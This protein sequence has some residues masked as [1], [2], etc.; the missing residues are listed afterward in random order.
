MFQFPA[1][2]QTIAIA[3]RVF[4]RGPALGA[5][6]ATPIRCPRDRVAPGHGSGGGFGVDRQRGRARVVVG[7]IKVARR[8]QPV[9]GSRPANAAAAVTEN[10]KT[11]GSGNG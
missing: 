8:H 4:R 7:Q 2:R 11:P 6:A 10:G 5:L 1:V 3:I 9:A